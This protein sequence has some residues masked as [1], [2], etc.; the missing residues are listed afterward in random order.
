MFTVSGYYTAME[1]RN[2]VKILIFQTR[3]THRKAAGSRLLGIQKPEPDLWVL[4]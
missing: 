2:R 3:Q 4:S 1:T